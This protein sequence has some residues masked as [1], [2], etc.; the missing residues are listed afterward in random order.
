MK[1]N[2]DRVAWFYDFL[3]GII[4]QGALMRSQQSLISFIHAPA[5]VL[6]VGGG[7]GRILEEIAKLQPGGLTIVYVEISEKMLEKSRKRDCGNNKVTF[8]LM[9]IDYYNTEE[10]FDVVLTPFLF[11]NF[12][13]ER[14]AQIFRIL[15]KLLVSKGIWLFA[16]FRLEN[17]KPADWRNRLLKS[18][19]AFFNI[20]LKI[21]A[22]NLPD[23]ASL[24][25]K[26]GYR[27]V[28]LEFHF[29]RFIYSLV[30]EKP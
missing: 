9:P 7:T 30:L 19:Y 28:F 26:A 25:K 11:D 8:L 18:M 24:F 21:E 20:F 16:D 4:F 6:I 1:N 27:Q 23:T 29:N 13:Q 12:S 14:A 3:G 10:E 15:D 22:K 5:R 17:K 2:Y